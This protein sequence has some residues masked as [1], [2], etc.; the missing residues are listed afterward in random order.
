MARLRWLVLI[1]LIVLPLVGVRA[2]AQNIPPQLA[3]ALDQLSSRLGIPI[4]LSSLDTWHFEANFY[5]NTALGCSFASGTDRPEGL[6]GYTI[7]LVY[8]GTT[9]D[10]R[11][12]GDNSFA[13]PC[14]Q[15]LLQQ[16]SQQPTSPATNCPADFAGFLPPRL[17]V[18]G[19]GRIGIDGTS[20]RLRDQPSINAQQIGLIKPGTTVDILEG[21]RCEDASHIIW[22]RVN[23]SG[24]VGWTAEGV[25]PDNYFLSP[26]GTSLPAERS[27]ISADNADTL[28][29]LATISLAGVS[30]I[31]F[32]GDGTLI[33]LG[34]LSGLAVYDMSTLS[35]KPQLG[36][37]SA[38]VTAVAFSPDGR[39]LAYS[40]QDGALQVY[41][42]P[43]TVRTTISPATNARVDSLAF[44][45]DQRY[46]LAVGSGSPTS[47]PGVPS[48]WQVYDLPNQRQLST[49]PTPSWVRAV[50]F[51]PDGQTF[52]WMDTSVSVVQV[53]TGVSVHTFTLEQPPTGGLAW[54][55]APIGTQ[56]GHAIAFADGARVRLENLDTNVEQDFTGDPDFRPAALA[57]S[58]NG[59]LLAAM[60]VP[61]NIA[62]ASTVNLFDANTS[63]WI[64]STPQQAS[65]AL[66]FSP[67]GT[68]LVIA[69]NDELLFLGIPQDIPVAVG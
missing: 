47:A 16:P 46:L 7:T 38:P 62:T 30:S 14:D 48:S 67:D 65:S 69:T 56:P 6:I 27:L 49:M 52:A 20:N 13:F 58:P 12:A 59:A 9:Y 18:G 64:T 19:Q 54:R 31:S 21:P 17:E 34:G 43:S 33:A 42:V 1:L 61:N 32:P 35:L 51:S 8:Q 36:D 4:T 55:P 60:N 63:D 44:S 5:T 3:L 2:Q 66:T 11:V 24:V 68:L 22:W 10:Y 53:A 39:Y 50:A 37:I 26:V 15:S 45:P 41:D 25:L 29:P 23:D 40:T 28:V 57:F